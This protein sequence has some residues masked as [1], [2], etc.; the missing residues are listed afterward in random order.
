M[1][2]TDDTHHSGLSG[3]ER[4]KFNWPWVKSAVTHLLITHWSGFIGAPSWT[5]DAV[6]FYL[7]ALSVLGEPVH[8]LKVVSALHTGAWKLNPRISE[9]NTVWSLTYTVLFY[10]KPPQWVCCKAVAKYS[11]CNQDLLDGSRHWWCALSKLLVGN[12]ML[13][14]IHSPIT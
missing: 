5:G 10:K 13:T 6:H 1:M 4:N 3:N 2:K 8:E 12:K 7:L 14:I 11:R 9:V